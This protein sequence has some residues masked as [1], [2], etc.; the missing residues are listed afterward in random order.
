MV[1]G[2]FGRLN[3]IG[4]RVC[5]MKVLNELIEQ[6]IKLLFFVSNKKRMWWS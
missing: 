6:V 2:G 3:N 4:E 5:G 1:T